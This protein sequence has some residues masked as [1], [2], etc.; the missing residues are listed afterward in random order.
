M[1]QAFFSIILLILLLW[2]AISDLRSRTIPDSVSLTMFGLFP[3]AALMG[4]LPGWPWH[5]LV[6]G[7]AF[8]VCIGLFA[9]GMMGGGD[10]KLIPVM[11]LWAGPDNLAP[12]LLLMALAGGLIAL[13]MVVVRL[14]R[15]RIHGPD[16]KAPGSIPYALAIAA[17][18]LSFTAQPVFN[19]FRSVLTGLGASGV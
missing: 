19:V 1:I 18:G 10:A 16:V 5:L 6:G 9:S 3:I 12:F 4:A 11:A 7:G 17:G 13:A 8:A 15:A 14:V 2:A